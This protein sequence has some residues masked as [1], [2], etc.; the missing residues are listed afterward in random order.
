[1]ADTNNGAARLQLA[2]LRGYARVTAPVR[3]RGLTPVA[4][5]LASLFPAG[6]E[7]VV[8]G[9]DS[10]R[11][12]ISLADGYWAKL[13]VGGVYEPDVEDLMVPLLVPG[14]TFVDCGANM[15]YWSVRAAKRGCDVI[16]I[17]PHPAQHDRL[18]HHLGLNGATARTVRAAVLD[19][20]GQTV[21]FYAEGMHHANSSVM[22]TG[23]S[24]SPIS[25]P[26]VTVDALLGSVDSPVV[27]KLDVEGVE[28][29]ALAGARRAV[30]AG[31][32]LIYEDHRNDD[33]HT[34][35]RAMF[36]AGLAVTGWESGRRVRLATIAE[37]GE[38]KR[39]RSVE[40]GGGGYNF[41]A[42]LQVASPTPSG[43]E[44]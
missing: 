2:L 38:L 32:T 27:V 13:L 35:S 40:R 1:M 10:S 6:T 8:D 21:S 42:S 30:A 39:R 34:S 9:P 24:V 11:F 44:L 31:A 5:K 15:G 16:S 19:R 43:E 26:S 25:V 33:L 3:Q 17:E 20:D 23:S 14:T 7:A 12:R 28:D 22:A 18:E 29:K 36:A 41:A 37:V 4:W